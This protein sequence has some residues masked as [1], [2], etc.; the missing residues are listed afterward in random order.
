DHTNRT[1]LSQKWHTE[2][3]TIGVKPCKLRHSVFRI[4]QNVWN[5]DHLALYGGSSGH[6]SPIDPYGTLLEV[7]FEF[8]RAAVI[9]RK[10]T[11]FSVTS[12]KQG[13]IRIAQ[14]GRRLHQC[15]EHR[16]QI[17]GRTADHLEHV[18]GGGLLLQ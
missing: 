8:A 13:V 16:L 4:N 7:R 12:E 6:R 1:A 5:V 9:R 11:R 18:G 3:R 15:V 10:M 17:E 2:H 14:W